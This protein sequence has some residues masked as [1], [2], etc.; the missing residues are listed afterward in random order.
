MQ[1]PT[2]KAIADG[3][4]ILLGSLGIGWVAHILNVLLVIAGTIWLI[5]RLSGKENYKTKKKETNDWIT[6][7]QKRQTKI[8]EYTDPHK[9]GEKQWSPT[10]WYYDEEKGKW[11]SPDYRD[12]S[13]NTSLPTYEA[14]KDWLYNESA[15]IWVNADQLERNRHQ[16]A[17]LE[18]RKRWKN[19][20]EQEAEEMR[21]Q[22]A[23]REQRKP[24]ELTQEEKDLSK[25]IRPDRAEP[26][27]EEWKAAR[28]KEQQD[29]Q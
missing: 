20:A 4:S 15:R 11:V 27:Y 25:Q 16:Q 29:K 28:L 9:A 13:K 8:Y 21:I 19:F 18:N 6:K 1:D 3:I 2:T 17:Y 23:L 7:A 22:A 10:G 26:S 14:S 12:G 24:A 5:K